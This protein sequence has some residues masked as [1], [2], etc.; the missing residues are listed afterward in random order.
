MEDKT[1]ENQTSEFSMSQ[2]YNDADTSRF[3][4]YIKNK[5]LSKS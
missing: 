3:S 4:V 2:F 1:G 5:V